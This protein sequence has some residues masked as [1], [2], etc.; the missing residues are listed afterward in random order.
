MLETG[1]EDGEMAGN[2]DELIRK[3]GNRKVV[4]GIVDEPHTGAH[5]EPAASGQTSNMQKRQSVRLAMGEP[6]RVRPVSGVWSHP[7]MSPPTSPRTPSTPFPPVIPEA[8]EA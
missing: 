8:K 3:V 5:E 7:S 1:H 4:Y 6:A 2:L